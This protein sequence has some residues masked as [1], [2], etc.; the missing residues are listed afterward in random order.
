MKEEIWR[1][2]TVRMAR[3]YVGVGR[4]S[5]ILPQNLVGAITAEGIKGNIIG[6]IEISDRYSLVEVP[7]EWIEQAIKVMRNGLIKGKKFPVRRF[8]EK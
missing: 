7:E 1:S 3:I 6:A 2:P 5:G 4:T 8:V